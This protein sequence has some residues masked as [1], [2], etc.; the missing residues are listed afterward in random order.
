MTESQKRK[1]IKA[2]A[3]KSVSGNWLS[4]VLLIVMYIAINALVISFLPLHLPL[5][6]EATVARTE[7][8]MLRL[9]LPSGFSLRTAA[10]MAVAFLLYLFLVPPFMIGMNRV[11]LSV[12]RGE[13]AR[14]SQV[15]SVFTRLSD[16]FSAIFLSIILAAIL[17]G[18]V[19]V[20]VIAFVPLIFIVFSVM[21]GS[22][23]L[24]VPVYL[25]FVA[26]LVI[27]MLWYSR[28]NF[29]AYILADGKDGGAIASLRACL[30]LVKGRSGECMKLRLSYIVWDLL[31]GYIPAL[32]IVYQ[33][34]YGTVYAKYLDY[35]RGDISFVKVGNPEE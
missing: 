35:F 33:I 25:A 8:D 27:L 7:S 26:A 11:F 20:L 16:V 9:F 13:K 17:I 10:S 3:W 18:L 15:F 4:L 29:A 22:Y 23:L 21:G 5:M 12:S 1:I 28:F 34:I 14:F 24:L 32:G 6:E 31:C 19:L 2:M 30:A